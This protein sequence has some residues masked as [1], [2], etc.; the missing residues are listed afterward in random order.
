MIWPDGSNFTVQDIIHNLQ[1]LKPVSAFR[2]K[3]DYDNFIIYSGK[4]R[5]HSCGKWGKLEKDFVEERIMK[6][7]EMDNSVASFVRLKD[8]NII[9]PVPIAE[10]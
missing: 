5:S 7:L 2:T 9:A 6:P 3:Y 10:N 8:T 1:Y 4:P